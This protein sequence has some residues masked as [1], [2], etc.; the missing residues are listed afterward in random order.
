MGSPSD[1]RKCDVEESTSR[2][3]QISAMIGQPSHPIGIEGV[4]QG[5]H[6][7]GGCIAGRS[8]SQSYGDAAEC[9]NDARNC[10]ADARDGQGRQSSEPGGECRE[11]RSGLE[12]Y[13]DQ[14]AWRVLHAASRT[15]SGGDS[16]FVV[17]V[18]RAA[19]NDNGCLA[20][21]AM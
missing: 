14:C 12:M 4:Y 3:K 18:L 19:V 5:G 15:A 8:A 17:Q 7:S 2:E 9:L 1:T 11:P 6:G 20:S 16:F 10:N 21:P 13:V